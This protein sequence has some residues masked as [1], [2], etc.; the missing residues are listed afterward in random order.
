[1]STA[2][3]QT[4]EEEEGELMRYS[5]DNGPLKQKLIDDPKHRGYK[6]EEGELM[7]YLIDNGPLKWKLIDDPKHLAKRNAKN[8][9]PLALVANSHASPSYSCSPQLYY[10]THLSFVHDYDDD[11]QGE[12]QDGCVDI[13]SKNV[14]YDRNGS[15]NTGRLNGNQETTIGNGFA[16]KNMETK[17]KVQRIPRTA[18]TSGKTNIQ[19]YNCNGKG[20]YARDYPEPRICDA[21]YFREQMLLTEKDKVRV[22]LDIEENDFMLMNAYS[23]DQLEELIA[24]VIMM[25]RIQPTDNK[26]DA[27]PRLMMLKLSMR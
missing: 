14:G 25:T 15:R 12:I 7:R 16:Q 1:M 3:Q 24:S 2:N 19:C 4:L 18:S 5:I 20:H 22:N 26:S 10:V 6:R 17:E 9:D 8:H 11:C 23:D 21:K 27:K 13:Q